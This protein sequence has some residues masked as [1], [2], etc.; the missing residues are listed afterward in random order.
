MITRGTTPYHRFIIPLLKEEINTIYITYLQNG[1]VIV[2]KE[3]EDMEIEN[4]VELIDGDIEDLTE[5][6]KLSCR[7][8]LHLSQEDTLKFHF[9]PAANKNITVIQIRVKDIDGE[10]Y[11]SDPIHQRIMGVLKEGEI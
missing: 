7:V 5:E 4:L 8:T 9:Y 6:E 1:E 2:E 11:S 10:A 3:L